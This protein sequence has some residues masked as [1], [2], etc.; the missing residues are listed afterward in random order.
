ML[1]NALMADFW[2]T[3]LMARHI[4]DLLRN[5]TLKEYVVNATYRDIDSLTWDSTADKILNVYSS[6]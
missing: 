6:L 4:I 3:D 5:K 2:D 1:P